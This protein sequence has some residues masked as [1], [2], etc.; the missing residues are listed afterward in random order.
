MDKQRDDIEKYLAGKLTSAEMHALEKKALSD[1][2]LAEALEGAEQIDAADFAN[3][4]A[5]LNEKL[6]KRKSGMWTWPLRIAATL[7]L[8]TVSM[9][10]IWVA[11]KKD[12]DE[13]LAL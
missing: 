2:F 4:I 6:T 9:F 11:L 8:L 7:L 13:T 5:A 3:D 1:P 12:T 10:V